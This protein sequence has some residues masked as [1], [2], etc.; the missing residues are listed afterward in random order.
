M[1]N[2]NNSCLQRQDEECENCLLN[3]ELNCYF[4]LKKLLSFIGVFSLFAVPSILGLILSDYALYLIGWFIFWIIFFEF[5]EIRI[6][7]SHCPFYAQEGRTIRC[8]ANYGSLKLWSYHPEPIS[9]IEKLQ[10]FIGFLILFGYPLL[11][12][13]LARQYFFLILSII[14][15]SCFTIFLL[16]IKCSKCVN[17]SCPLNRV[18]KDVV[19]DFLKRNTIM[20]EAWEKKGYKVT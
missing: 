5:W 13:L 14:G 4:E 3:N 17:F 8:I 10:L 16:T 15:L 19:N 11:F 6:L 1:D 18:S 9:R 20:R 2:K 7:C 12:L